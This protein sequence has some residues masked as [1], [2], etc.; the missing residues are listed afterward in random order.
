MDRFRPSRLT[1]LAFAAVALLG[2][3]TEAAKLPVEAG[4]GPK[5]ELPKP[6]HRALPTVDIARATGWPEGKAPTAAAGLRVNAFAAG[7][8]H[9]RWLYVLPNG[10]VLVAETA[11]PP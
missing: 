4:M 9:P 3:C 8:E 2:A 11:A 10:D 1:I 5:P 7:L 6:V